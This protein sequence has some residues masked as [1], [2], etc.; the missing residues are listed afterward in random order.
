MA[1]WTVFAPAARG[2]GGTR[3]LE[4]AAMIPG[5][6]KICCQNGTEPS[7][8]SIQSG[9]CAGRS[10]PG[11]VAGAAKGRAAAAGAS[12]SA[13]K[14]PRRTS[15]FTAASL[16]AEACEGAKTP[17]GPALP[18]LA[19]FGCPSAEPNES[20]H[21]SREARGGLSFVIERALDLGDLRRLAALGRHAVAVGVVLR[22]AAERE[23]VEGER[24]AVGADLLQRCKQRLAI[25]GRRLPDHALGRLDLDRAVPLE[26][27]R[28]RDQLADDHV[29][30]EAE[31][32]VDL[33][34]DRRVGQH[35]R[36]LLE[37]GGR[38]ERLGR[39]RRLR[40]PED[41]WLV[42]RL[43][44]LLLLHARVLALEDDPVDQL[45]GQK[46]RIAGVLDA[47]LLEHLPHD[48]LDVLVVDLDALRL[49]DLLH[50]ADEV[51]L[52]RG[53]ALQAEQVGRCERALVEGVAGLDHL[54]V[55]DQQARAP[56]NLVR[57][58][59]ERLAVL[60]EAVLVDD[61][62]R[63]A[64]VLLDLD[65]PADLGQ[66]GGALGVPGLEDL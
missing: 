50:L 60:V 16:V 38:E 44:A 3:K 65:P 35:L 58:R 43:L 2:L 52:G 20:R 34:L 17:R 12:A 66:L 8:K 15:F 64:V 28:G 33:A 29:L 42:R 46:L 14:A 51:Q 54:P 7:P 27:R 53:R 62:L 6:A 23:V 25:C 9:R 22:L 61:H 18:G 32:V 4:A 39:E 63:A 11:G 26:A 1:Q 5:R 30:L 19:T 45:A 41:Q 55:L 57:D 59:L 36:R 40:D 49:V 24:P 10:Q 48:Q 13:T 37:G 47:D 21:A 56:R 31:Q